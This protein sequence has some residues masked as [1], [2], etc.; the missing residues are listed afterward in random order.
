MDETYIHIENDDMKKQY[1]LNNMRVNIFFINKF[2][3]NS[4]SIL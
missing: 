2:M 4:I 3:Q 1:F